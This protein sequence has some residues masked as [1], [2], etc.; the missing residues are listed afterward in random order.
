MDLFR[1]ANS[2]IFTRYTVWGV[3]GLFV[4]SVILQHVSNVNEWNRSPKTELIRVF[5]WSSQLA[6]NVGKLLARLCSYLYHLQLHKLGKAFWDVL[7][8]ILQFL[9]LPYYFL[10][11]YVRQ[12]LSYTH[13]SVI[14]LGGL[15]LVVLTGY[16]LQWKWGVF[17]EC[18]RR[19]FG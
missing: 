3:G 9:T 5:D 10:D 19:V 6:A 13:P 18:Y 7:G 14:Y 17:S 16:G 4:G 11:G 1:T 8:P 12:A 15:G 2:Y